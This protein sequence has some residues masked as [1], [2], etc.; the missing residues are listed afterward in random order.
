MCPHSTRCNP[1]WR[2]GQLVRYPTNLCPC[3]KAAMSNLITNKHKNQ[4]HG[5][6]PTKFQKRQ[7]NRRIRR[8][9]TNDDTEIAHVGS[10]SNRNAKRKRSGY[11]PICLSRLKRNKRMT[12]YVR[13]CSSCTAQ[14][15]PDL[16]CDRCGTNRVWRGK[17]ECRCK[18]C[19]NVVVDSD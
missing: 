14:F 4:E 15:D 18:G 9:S 3:P 7:A 8:T 16:R 2:L 11:C 1:I 17:N 5:E 6:R 12:R 13:Q 19:G 10:K